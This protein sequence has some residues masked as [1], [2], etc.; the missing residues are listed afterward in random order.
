MLNNRIELSRD[1][2]P[3]ALLTWHLP[4][5]QGHFYPIAFQVAEDLDEAAKREILNVAERPVKMP[6]KEYRN[7]MYG[8]SDHFG[9]LT[10]PLGRLG[11]RARA[12]GPA[13]HG[14]ALQDRPIEVP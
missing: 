1:G 14:H 8:S 9:E 4:D 10:R 13:Q 6:A 2:A 7:A 5:D 11:Y 3:K 12:F